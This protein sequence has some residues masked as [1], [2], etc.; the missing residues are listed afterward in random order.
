M[1][2]RVSLES[3][4]FNPAL[5]GILI[6]LLFHPDSYFRYFFTVTLQ[7]TFFVPDRT[8]ITAVPLRFAVIFPFALTVATFVLELA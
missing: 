3:P 7:V 1:P 2:Q 5:C 8:V 6:L 4:D